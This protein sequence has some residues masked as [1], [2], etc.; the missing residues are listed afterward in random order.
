[1]FPRKKKDI[2]VW[3]DCK[4]T[5]TELKMLVNYPFKANKKR[6]LHNIFL[7]ITSMQRHRDHTRSHNALTITGNLR[8]LGED[9]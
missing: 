9:I 6:H 4:Y 3:N 8:E 1:M 5:M 7:S 2:Q